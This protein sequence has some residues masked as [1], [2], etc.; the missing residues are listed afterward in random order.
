[1]GTLDIFDFWI[2]QGWRFRGFDL[3]DEEKQKIYRDRLAYEVNIYKEKDFVDY[4][5][6]LSDAVRWA[7]DR[8]P[9]ECFGD[10]V[11]RAGIIA[12]VIDSA[13]D[14]YAA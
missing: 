3:F 14:F 8:N 1:M 5:L 4:F 11:I 12:P 9:G 13:R 7:K 2:E 6:M 10:F